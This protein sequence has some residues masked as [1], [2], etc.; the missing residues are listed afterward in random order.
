MHSLQ[1][2]PLA[3]L[4][5]ELLARRVPVLRIGEARVGILRVLVAVYVGV[6]ALLTGQALAGQSVVRPDA[7]ALSLAL[8]LVAAA[9]VA[10][11]GVI[12]QA[13]RRGTMPATV[14]AISSSRGPGQPA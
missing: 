3:A 4:L 8:A 2:L 1:L 13:R 5:L 7:L 9:A 6:L 14:V 12:W 10:I 11:G